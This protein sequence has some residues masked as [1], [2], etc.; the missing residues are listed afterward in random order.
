MVIPMKIHN[1]VKSQ[2]MPATM[3]QQSTLEKE[4]PNTRPDATLET[5][6]EATRQPTI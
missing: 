3:K 6:A 1:E 2:S 4:T 5:T